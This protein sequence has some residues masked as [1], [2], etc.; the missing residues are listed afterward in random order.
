LVP[1]FEDAKGHKIL[2]V[3]GRPFTALAVEIPWWDL[4]YGK[5][6]ETQSVYDYVHPVAKKM[7]LN[8]LKV[9]VKWSMVEQ[10]R[11]V[12]DFSYVDH[13]KRMAEKHRLELALNWFGHYASGNGTIYRN[14]MG[15][16]FARCT[17]DRMKKHIRGRWMR[18]ALPIM[19][20]C[21]TTTTPWSSAK[22]RQISCPPR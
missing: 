8:T 22:R 3:D 2:Y 17:S 13:A 19:T 20:Q 4:I 21:P 9:S 1:H 12:Y 7:G 5:Y 6:T 18:T 10:E 15:E 14:L 11:G 16:L